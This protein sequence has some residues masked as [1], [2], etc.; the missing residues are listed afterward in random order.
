MELVLTSGP[1][2]FATLLPYSVAYCYTNIKF[3]YWMSTI[4]QLHVLKVLYIY[5]LGYPYEFWKKFC[6]HH[7][8]RIETETQRGWIVAQDG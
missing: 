6:Y 7:F 1:E 4:N 3:S 2:F 5:D 8:L